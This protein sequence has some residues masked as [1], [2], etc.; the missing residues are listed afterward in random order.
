[1][2][3]AVIATGGKQYKVAQGDII[4]IDRIADADQSITFSDVLLFVGDNGTKIGTPIL[5]E[6]AVIGKVLD[7]TKGK[8]IKVAKFKAKAKYRRTTGFR[9]SLT[10][11][12][13]ESISMKENNNSEKSAPK[14]TKK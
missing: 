4:T 1:M 10:R 9:A 5:T 6:A 8:K 3:Y 2:I 7:H 11:V 13:I 12:Q 14:A